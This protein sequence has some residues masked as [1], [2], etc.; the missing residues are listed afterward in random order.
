[1]R[2]RLLPL[3]ALAIVL[4]IAA[5][6]AHAA[7]G[8][9]DAVVKHLETEYK[10]STNESIP[11]FVRIAVKFV[12]PAGV[13]SVKLKTFDRLTGTGGG[14]RLD[15]LLRAKLAKDWQ[16]VVR[17]FSK[18]HREQV[19]IYLRPAKSDVEILVVAVDEEDATVLKAKVDPDR[20]AD[21][22]GDI[23]AIASN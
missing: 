13:K 22:L 19:F 1:M 11:F 6:S 2:R 5:P 16:P 7:D 9:F 3:L 18:R 23:D 8:D 4:P 21:F 17:I 10:A 12:K 15:A 20:L 14:D